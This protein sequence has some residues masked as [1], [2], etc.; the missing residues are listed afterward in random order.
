MTQGL[1][2]KKD[3]VS[4]DDNAS[5]HTPGTAQSCYEVGEGEL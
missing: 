2:P 5:I 3:A 4:Q 1:F